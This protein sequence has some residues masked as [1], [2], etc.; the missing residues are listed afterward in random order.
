MYNFDINQLK[1]AYNYYRHLEYTIQENVFC[2]DIDKKSN[3]FEYLINLLDKNN[4][5]QARYIRI[6]KHIL[7]KFFWNNYKKFII[8]NLWPQ[9]NL[10]LVTVKDQKVDA[11]VPVYTE[12]NMC[13]VQNNNVERLFIQLAYE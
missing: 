8:T 13:Y 3:R 6:N 7:Y 4:I 12:N 2:L 1:E 5:I 10:C 9:H 11:R